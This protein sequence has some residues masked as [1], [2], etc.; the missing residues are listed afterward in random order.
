MAVALSSSSS[1]VKPSPSTL[2]CRQPG[3]HG[4]L[5]DSIRCMIQGSSARSKQLA[6]I[7]PHYDADATKEQQLL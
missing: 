7:R 2:T 5:A 1:G 6:Q 4:Q 3:L